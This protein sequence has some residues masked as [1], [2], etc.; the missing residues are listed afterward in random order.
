MILY[1]GSISEIRHP[2]VSFSKSNLDFASQPVIDEALI[3]V[4]TLQLE[5]IDD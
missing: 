4:Q 3:F 5:A 2:D 1:H